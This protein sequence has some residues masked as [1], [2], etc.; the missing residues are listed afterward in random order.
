M[1]YY[2]SLT[3]KFY[4]NRKRVDPGLV[5][6]ECNRAGPGL[7][8]ARARKPMQV[9]DWSIKRHQAIVIT[10][11]F[12]TLNHFNMKGS[13]RMASLVFALVFAANYLTFV[14]SGK[15]LDI[16]STFVPKG[17]FASF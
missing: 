7:I 4:F 13:S 3:L 15:W 17:K 5:Q 16:Q 8:S 10:N 6:F 1:V 14:G 2:P 12:Q 11:S 9:S